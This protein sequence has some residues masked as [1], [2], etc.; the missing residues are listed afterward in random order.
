MAAGAPNHV[1]TIPNPANGTTDQNKQ[2]QV[3]DVPRVVDYWQRAQ[4]LRAAVLGANDG[5]VSV[6]SLM[7]GVGAVNKDAKAMLLAGF[8][9]L[10]AGACGMAIG[11]F[12]SVFTQYEVEVGQMKRD[13]I[14]SEQGE[15]DLEMAMEK[16]KSIPNPMQAALASAFSFSIGG[17]VPLLSGSFVSVYKIRLLVIVVVVS[18][19]LVAFGSVG[20]LLGKTPMTR[21]CVRF[22]IGG[23]MAMAITFGLTKLLSA[24]GLEI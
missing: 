1:G 23:W 6:A 18:L 3:T 10:V 14:K 19:A 2:T 12:V 21:S 13:M 9:G 22:M 11:E 15:R 17:L 8:A 24:G 4:W 7:M 5:L 16:R 20:S